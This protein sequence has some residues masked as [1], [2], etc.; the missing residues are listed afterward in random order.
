MLV[1]GL[2]TFKMSSLRVI[3]LDKE[4]PCRRTGYGKTFQRNKTA[5][6]FFHNRSENKVRIA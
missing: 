2:V 5:I 3:I 6:R 1:I 4:F